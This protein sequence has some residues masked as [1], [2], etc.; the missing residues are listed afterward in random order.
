MC[1]VQPNVSKVL[2]AP[3]GCFAL[4]VFVLRGSTVLLF[5]TVGCFVLVWIS[6]AI[7]SLTGFI[8]FSVIVIATMV[9]PRAFTLH[10]MIEN[11][12]PLFF[13]HFFCF[14]CLLVVSLVLA[15][16]RHNS[17]AVLKLEFLEKW[18]AANFMLVL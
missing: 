2:F 6:H 8:I 5:A 16:L 1:T 13:C 7:R 17:L 15:N 3:S 10:C 14:T 12:L 11:F 18:T 9:L 4:S